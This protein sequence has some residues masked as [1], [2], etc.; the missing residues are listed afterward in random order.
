MFIQY[1]H[2]TYVNVNR[3]YIIYDVYIYIEKERVEHKHT[4]WNCQV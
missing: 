2:N 4:L 1:I 3:I